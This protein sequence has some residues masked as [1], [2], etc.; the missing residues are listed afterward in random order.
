MTGA[1]H[2]FASVK[3]NLGFNCAL[4]HTSFLLELLNYPSNSVFVLL[5]VFSQTIFQQYLATD[6][7]IKILFFCFFLKMANRALGLLLSCWGGGVGI[8]V[9]ISFFLRH[10]NRKQTP[11]SFNCLF[12]LQTGMHFHREGRSRAMTMYLMQKRMLQMK[13][14]GLNCKNTSV[15]TVIR[16]VW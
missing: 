5:P 8:S 1:G 13:V 9:F 12:T 15:Q 7:L 10:W 16:S 14:N 4:S 2:F 3:N 6:S 11:R